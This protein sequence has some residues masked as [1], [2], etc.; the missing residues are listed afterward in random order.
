MDEN[1]NKIDLSTANQIRVILSLNMN[2]IHL[3][4]LNYRHTHTH[5]EFAFKISEHTRQKRNTE[6]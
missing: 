2:A 3:I 5:T 6:K 4:E 1:R